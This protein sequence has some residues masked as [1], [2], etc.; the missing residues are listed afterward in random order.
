MAR[1][2]DDIITRIKQEVS[3]L[4][5][6][7]TQGYTLNPHGSD[8]ALQCPFHDDKTASL[9]IT[10]TKNLYHCFGCRAAGSVID[11]VMQTEKLNFREAVD[12][13][14]SRFLPLAASV[15]GEQSSTKQTPSLMPTA[16][17]QALLHTVVDYYH[18][19]LLQSP[20]ALDYLTRRGLNHP[21]LIKTFKLGYANRTLSRHLSETYTNNASAVREA[22]QTLGIY[23]ES[24][25]EHFNGSI[26]VPVFNQ[27]GDVT[28]AYGRK[29]L[30]KRL[31]KGTAIHAYLPG[32]HRGVW[33]AQGLIGSTT[34]ILCE[35]LLDAMTFWCAG[36]TNVTS[37]YGTNGFTEDHL[38]L[39]IVQGIKNVLIAYDRDKA[40]NQ[41]AEA[42]ASRL[43]EKGINTYRVLLPKDMDVNA[44][45]QHTQSVVENLGLLLKKAEP[46]GKTVSLEKPATLI[47]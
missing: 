20:E 30:G 45:A 9:V 18:E 25:H 47:L 43:N 44:Y 7:Q 23:R 1:L 40:G 46:I 8:Y 31:R 41:A 29:V 39:F 24:G 28:E 6:V 37:S 32:M 13:L 2:S 34:I 4:T 16:E 26:V 11:W 22:L 21:A 42:L 27:Q 3:L 38:T 19:T 12:K 14:Q 36:F 15:A 10:P 35:A 17:Q 33:N 5:W